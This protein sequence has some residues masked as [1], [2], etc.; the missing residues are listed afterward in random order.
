MSIYLLVLSAA[1]NVICGV[2]G[3][4]VSYYNKLVDMV[5]SVNQVRPDYDRSY[6]FPALVKTLVIGWMISQVRNELL[7]YV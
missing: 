6:L 1:L 2:V 4:P 7:L 3:P 5:R